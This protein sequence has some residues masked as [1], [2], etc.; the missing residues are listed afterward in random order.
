MLTSLLRLGTFYTGVNR[1]LGPCSRAPVHTTAEH[2]PKKRPMNT[3]S[4]L[5][6]S[7]LYDKLRSPTL[8][9]ILNSEWLTGE[10]N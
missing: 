7:I 5:N 4:V 8:A 2:G 1:V 9:L 10:C 6:W 3:S